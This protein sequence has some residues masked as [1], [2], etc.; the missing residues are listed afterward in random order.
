MSTFRCTWPSCPA[1]VVMRTKPLA[2]R[3]AAFTLI[4]L[5]VVI[6]I[7]AILIAL[8]VPAVQK[9]REAAAKTQC[10]N[11]VKQILIGVH[12]YESNFKI[13]PVQYPHYQDTGMTNID[14]TGVSWMFTILPYVEQGPLYDIV[15]PTGQVAASLGMIRPQ[16]RTVIAT[17]VK[18]YFCPSDNKAIGT[19]HT[20]I[21]LLP[22]IPFAKMNYA[23]TIGDINYGNSS[24]FGGA[25]DCH[26]FGATGKA[27]CP[28]T[29]WRHS[30]MS[31]VKM[32]HYTD[33][34]SNTFIMGEVLPEF[35]S[36][37]AWAWSNSNKSTAAPLNYWPNP[38]DPWNGWPNQTGFRSKHAGGAFFGFGDG[39][40]R[41]LSQSINTAVY[42]GMSTRK[43]NEPI[44][45][46]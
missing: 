39:T 31:P 1:E 28:G 20:D 41:F 7:I 23:G 3:R 21:W 6:A 38:N 22:G 10:S 32:A 4:E 46:D 44:N 19:V 27:E 36:F 24:I 29:F 13:I 17:S 30:F 34:T 18:L 37:T 16:N 12:S 35:D 15:D 25:A 9:V 33:G 5:L 45:F 42:R 43:G 14:G 8:L 40:V 2:Q 26:N 11:N